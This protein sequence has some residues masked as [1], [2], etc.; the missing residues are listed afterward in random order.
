MNPSQVLAKISIL[1]CIYE[2]HILFDE[3]KTLISF[4]ANLSKETFKYI[5]LYKIIN[6]SLAW[7]EGWKVRFKLL[8]HVKW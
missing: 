4:I 6:I 7:R 5:F 8:S 3:K 2:I 1:I